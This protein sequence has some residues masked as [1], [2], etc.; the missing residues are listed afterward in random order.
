MRRFVELFRA[1]DSTTSTNAKIDALV[2]YFEDADDQSKLWTIA[3]FTHRR[4]RRTVSTT[5]LRTWA[6][7]AGNIPLWIFEES[8]HIVGD[9]AETIAAVL[10]Y[11]AR[12]TDKPLH[13]F[14]TEIQ[15]LKGQDEEV[16]KSYIL[17]AW[18]NLDKDGR[19]LFNKLITGGFR[20]G[21]SSKSIVKA[22]AKYTGIEEEKIAHRLMGNWTPAATTFHK[23]IIE[24]D[25]DE[26]LSKPYPF[27]LAYALE[28]DV[29]EIGNLEDWLIDYKWDG[30]RGQLILR[31]DQAF[32]WTRGEELVNH[33]YPELT[34][35]AESLPN[36]DVVL[37]GEIMPFKDGA[38][39]KFNDLQRRLGRKKVGK[40]LLEEVPIVFM[41]YDILEYAGEDIRA[42]P[43]IIRRQFLE[44][45]VTQVNHENLKISPL[46][47]AQKWDEIAEIR[48][49][50][51]EIGAEG[52]MLKNKSSDYKT[53]RVKGEWWKWKVDP[54]TVDAVMLYARRGSGRRS[55]LYT[56]FT[57]AVKD[58]AGGLVP[59]A[60]A[61]SGLKDEEFQEITQWVRSNTRERF[62]PVAS[63]H[64]VHV[65]EIAFEGI[66]ESTRHKSG[67]AVRFPRIKRWRKDKPVDEINT[68]E[69]LKKLI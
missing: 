62:G 54:M 11:T 14:I 53:G 36:N 7:E 22:L 42:K 44:E 43:I 65:F 17:A 59:F 1:L 20:L 39:M 45:V 49:Q 48:I 38:P 12:F 37:D 35:L 52:L 24:N 61:Y 47:T 60:K 46:V 40:K 41:S 50:A 64:P 15:E 57:F 9:L 10:P 29:A 56:D 55:N 28:G 33:A 21:V 2:D 6:A 8:Y 5:L 68:L 16:V 13:A 25:P 66:A 51:P 34:I 3:L 63:V 23:L 18:K 67:I 27:Y 32:V 69:D 26:N 30:I 4:P 19:F 31:D 58:G